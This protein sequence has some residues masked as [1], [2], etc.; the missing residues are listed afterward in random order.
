MGRIIV[1]NI[2]VTNSLKPKHHLI[3]KNFVHTSKKAQQITV[4]NNNWL[5][6]FKE[7]IPVKFGIIWNP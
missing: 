1:T 6:M 2:L 3:L 7:V 4:M 5:M